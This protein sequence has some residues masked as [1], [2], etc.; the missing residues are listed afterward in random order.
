MPELSVGGGFPSNAGDSIG[1]TVHVKGVADLPVGVGKGAGTVEIF[2]PEVKKPT[3]VAFT[4]ESGGKTIGS[5]QGRSGARPEND[6][7]CPAA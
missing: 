4:L 5:R 7:L 2:A 1:V 3:T 6:H